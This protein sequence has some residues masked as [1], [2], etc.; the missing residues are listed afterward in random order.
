VGGGK[1]SMMSYMNL[2]YPESRFGGYTDVDGTITFYTRVN[3][4]ITPSS[5]MLDVGCGRGVYGEDPVSVRRQSRIFK[6]RCQKVTGIDVDEAGAENP[7]LDEFRRIEG[8][9]WPVPDE[10]VDV[11]IA[12]NVLEHLENPQAFFSETARVLKT[13]GY[14]GIRTPN[15]L[16]YIGLFSRMIPNRFHASVLGKVQEARKEEDV[17]P[18]LYRC[19]TK[20]RIRDML[21]NYGFDNH[22]YEFESEPYYVSFSRPFYF[23]GVLHQRFAINALRA[24]LFAF[25][26]KQATRLEADQSLDRD[27]T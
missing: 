15:A 9:R 23:L 20:K 3:S 13:G 25:A 5:V 14:L 11:C 22:V 27:G 4:F 19:N 7:F 12:D 24:S 26:R 16:N 6:G 10:S 21:N 18:T 1:E 8:D 17:F 2:Y